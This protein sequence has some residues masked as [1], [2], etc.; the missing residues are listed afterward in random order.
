M[1][2]P[3]GEW[4]VLI[5]DHLVLMTP[6]GRGVYN[7]ERKDGTSSDVMVAH[8]GS[9]VRTFKG[10]PYRA[11]MTEDTMRDRSARIGGL[12]H[13]PA[14]RCR[15]RLTKQRDH[16]VAPES[17]LDRSVRT[18][19]PIEVD[20]LAVWVDRE[21]RWQTWVHEGTHMGKAPIVAARVLSD[22]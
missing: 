3:D 22:A 10:V 21:D 8:V 7:V 2:A 15:T 11:G 18:R 4:V 1:L 9:E 20:G 5:P 13:A 16:V 12:S 17:V 19:K 6:G 14:S